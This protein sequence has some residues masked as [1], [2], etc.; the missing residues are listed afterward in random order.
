MIQQFEFEGETIRVANTADG[1]WFCGKDV[2]KVLSYE[3]SKYALQKLIPGDYKRSLKEILNISLEH[4]HSNVKVSYN[5]GKAVYINKEGVDQ[6]LTRSRVE[7]AELFKKWVSDELL[8]KPKNNEEKKEKLVE[9]SPFQQLFEFEGFK[10]RVIG[11]PDKPWFCGK[12]VCK[13]LEYKDTDNAI[14]TNVRDKNKEKLEN[15]LNI[16]NPGKLPG[17]VGNEKASIY[18]DEPGLYQLIMKSRME[19]AVEFQDWVCERI[20]LKPKNNEEKE[21]KQ[22]VDAKPSPFQQ[23]FEFEGL[24]VRIIGTPDKP[25]FCGKD[26]C[27]VLEYE[28]IKDALQKLI[29]SKYKQPLNKILNISLGCDQHP[30]S[31]VGYHKGKAVYINEAG[32]YELIFNSKMEK[33]RKFKDWVF[34]EVLPKIRKNGYYVAPNINDAEVKRLREELDA[35]DQLLKESQKQLEER[36][37]QLN[38]L[39][40]IQIELLTYKKRITRDETIYIVSTA[41]YARQGIFKIGRTKSNMKARNSGHNNTHIGGDKVKVI[42]EFKVNDATAVERNIHTKLGGLL[43]DGE[44]EFFMCPFDLLEV[45]VDLI[46]NN[47]DK[48]NN[49]VNRIIDT[50]YKI[51]Q[52]A[53]NSIDWT[54]GIPEALFQEKMTILE[55]DEKLAELDVS[56]WSNAN[57]K[58]FVAKCIQEYFKMKKTVDTTIIWKKLQDVLIEQLSIPKSRFRVKDWKTSVKEQVEEKSLSIKWKTSD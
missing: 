19:K 39:H 49:A 12:D 9:T 6:F 23:L 16:L 3:N 57:K 8:Q 2:C 52:R 18:I 15:I 50:V 32:L 56:K 5:E 11:S 28:N 35:R 33:A 43:V 22:R 27:K 51:K 36:D 17:L 26:V 20:L 37:A 25:W 54:S 14:K 44:K 21:E 10:V 46:V 53:F 1:I 34:E 41:N 7:G 48:E 40:N 30:N 45:V 58:E 42:K 31:D 13:V 4:V 47:D 24:Q 29:P 55:E 38:I